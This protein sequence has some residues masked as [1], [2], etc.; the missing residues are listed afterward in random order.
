MFSA[1][2]QATEFLDPQPLSKGKTEKSK[3]KAKSNKDSKAAASQ[4]LD[5]GFITLPAPHISHNTHSASPALGSETG[6]PAPKPGFARIG[7]GGGFNEVGNG[8]G[9]GV[10]TPVPGQG[11][12][13]RVTFGLK[14][15]AGEDAGGTPPSKSQ[16]YQ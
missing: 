9:S 12:R 8:S 2:P 6:S 3:S 5:G 4:T 7:G 11:D 14:R 10:G 1:V 13:T 15:K 16:R